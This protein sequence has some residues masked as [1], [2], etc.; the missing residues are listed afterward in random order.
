MKILEMNL[1][2]FL[3]PNSLILPTWYLISTSYIP[4]SPV[5][6]YCPDYAIAFISCLHAFPIGIFF[7][8]S[9]VY[10]VCLFLL[11]LS[12]HTLFGVSFQKLSNFFSF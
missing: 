3:H 12:F 11:T 8:N 7:T 9:L 10:S 1:N 5:L 6:S 2:G 4:P